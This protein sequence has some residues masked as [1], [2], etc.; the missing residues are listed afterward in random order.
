L[1]R[2]YF[3]LVYFSVSLDHLSSEVYDASL[4]GLGFELD[5]TARLL[6]VSVEVIRT[7]IETQGVLLI[8]YV[9]I[10]I[11]SLS[12]LALLNNCMSWAGGSGLKFSSS[13]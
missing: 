1:T 7:G 6:L 11:V 8:E 3:L 12:L 9:V 2:C 4:A 10:F 5:V 13:R